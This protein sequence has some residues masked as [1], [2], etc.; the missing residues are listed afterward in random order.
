M[1]NLLFVSLLLLIF[2]MSCSEDSDYTT[3]TVKYN[4]GESYNPRPI[5]SDL[6]F[7][8]YSDYSDQV[9][10]L[11]NHL[12]RAGYGYKR[13]YVAS[14]KATKIKVSM[15][16]YRDTAI[17]WND[18]KQK[19]DTLYADTSFCWVQKMYTLKNGKN[20]S[21]VIDDKTQLGEEE[22]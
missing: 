15:K 19:H 4:F 7:Y 13:I 11:I 3:Y 17:V 8:E 5:F 6:D 18:Q 14:E 2:L 12:S 22:P 9:P 16:Q 21:I 10:I 20:I 1:R